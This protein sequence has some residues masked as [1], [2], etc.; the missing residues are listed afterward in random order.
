MKRIAFLLAAC[1]LSLPLAAQTFPSKPVRLI[2][3]YAPGGSVDLLARVMR[4]GLQDA[5]GRP[6]VV[7]NRAGA[8]GAIGIEAV[9]KSPPDGHTLGFSGPGPVPANAPLTKQ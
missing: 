8:G 7:E 9:A 2:V 1:A 6:V 3:P 5:L 4:D